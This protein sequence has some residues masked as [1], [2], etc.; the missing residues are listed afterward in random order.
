VQRL[1][2]GAILLLNSPRRW[3]RN[4]LSMQRNTNRLAATVMALFNIGLALAT[5]QQIESAERTIKRENVGSNSKRGIGP[6]FTRSA[7]WRQSQR[8][9]LA[10]RRGN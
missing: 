9:K 10:R 7:G 5:G 2:H 8:R 6:W 4:G 1:N 3:R